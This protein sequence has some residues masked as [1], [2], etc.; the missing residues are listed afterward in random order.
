MDSNNYYLRRATSPTK[1]K[2][3]HKGT[4]QE[5]WMVDLSL[6]LP[7]PSRPDENPSYTLATPRWNDVQIN[8]YLDYCNGLANLDVSIGL[9][10]LTTSVF[11]ESQS[12]MPVL[13]IDPNDDRYGQLHHEHCPA[14]DEG[15]ASKLAQIASKHLNNGYVRCVP[16]LRQKQ[17]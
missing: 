3:I 5:Q 8:E 11:M 6:F 7:R 9:L 1:V 13:A 12:W 10:E 2:L 14:P 17:K 4:I 16:A 15:Q